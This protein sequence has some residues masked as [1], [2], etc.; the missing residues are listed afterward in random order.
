V[1]EYLMKFALDH[2]FH[3]VR[4]PDYESLYFDEV[5]N[6][7]LGAALTMGRRLLKLERTAGRVVRHVQFEPARDPDSAAGQAFG[8][9]RASF[10][11]ELDYDTHGHRGTW[12]TIPNVWADRV[13]NSGSLE[14][15]DEGGGTRRTVRGEVRVSLFGFGGLV[16]R[17]IVNE[18]EKN[19]AR[20]TAFTLDYL[21]RSR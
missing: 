18:I 17:A 7:E 21:A 11:E 12:K 5:F 16:E 4:L 13:R 6:A 19:Y 3:A 1:W 15:A 2:I 20:S 10:I 14:L 8:T 9:S